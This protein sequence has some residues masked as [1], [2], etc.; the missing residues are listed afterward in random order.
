MTKVDTIRRDLSLTRLYVIYYHLFQLS[1]FIPASIC[2]RFLLLPLWRNLFS[3]HFCSIYCDILACQLPWNGFIQKILTVMG[4]YGS[5]CLLQSWTE[6]LNTKIVI[7]SF[8]H[9]LHTGRG[10]FFHIYLKEFFFVIVYLI[11]YAMWMC[12]ETKNWFG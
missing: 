6:Y 9:S 8:I 1:A 4:C 12:D 3:L 7:H 2:F 10:T 5:K 11:P